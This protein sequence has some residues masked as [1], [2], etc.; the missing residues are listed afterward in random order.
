MIE[1]ALR[2]ITRLKEDAM[3]PKI[4]EIDGKTYC[5]KNL[6]RYDMKNYADAVKVSTL[7][8]LVDYIKGCP[9]ELSD[10]MIIR[11]VSPSRVILESTLDSERER[12]TMVMVEADLP[13][14]EDDRWM[15]Q[16]KFMITLQ[17]MFDV[18][19]DKDILLQIAG[20]IVNNTTADYGDDGVSQKT[21]IK[22]GIASRMD[23]K[24]PN[25]VTLRPYRTFMEIAQPESEFVFRIDGE[26]EKPMFKLVDA[27]GKKWVIEARQSIR[28]YLMDALRDAGA[29]KDIIIIA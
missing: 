3:E 25:P 19:S 17:A 18:S 29:G 23:V 16:E 8:A 9:E 22:Q 24:V 10:K 1:K 28:D 15:D 13:R 21:T 7:T 20:N 6:N 26:S 12:E 27:N 11:V 14:F 5:N 2:F 4:V